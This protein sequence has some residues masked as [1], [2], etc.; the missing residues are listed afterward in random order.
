VKANLLA[1][2]AAVRLH[3]HNCYPQ[4]TWTDRL[5][6]ALGT[7]I[8]PIVIEQDLVWRSGATVVAHEAE[9]AAAAPTLEE[10]FFARVG[11]MLDRALAEG[12]R[13]EWPVAVL[14][15]DFKTNEP[16]H[17]AEVWRLLGK[18]ERW[19]TTAERTAD[20]V[21]VTPLSPGPLLVLTERGTG[22][23]GAFH[24]RIPVGA[25]LRLFGT[26]APLPPPAGREKDPAA[27]VEAAPE[28]LIP[29]GATNYRRWTNHSW[30][31]V[32]A[33]GPQKAGDWTPADRARLERIVTRAHDVGLWV[34]FYTLN[35]H[36]V[37][38]NRGWSAS[39]NFGSLDAARA[40]WRAA[41]DARVDFVA[42][43]QY[44]DFTRELSARGT[45]I[46]YLEAANDA[47]KWIRSTAIKTAA[48]L[49]WP[50]DPND[51]KSAGNTTL[52]SGSPGVVLFL[53]ELHKATGEASY[54]AD[55]RAGADELIAQLSKV[56]GAGLYVGLAGIGFTLAETHLATGDLRY[57]DAFAQVV[58]TVTE[59]ARPAGKG[60]DWGGVTDIIAG[61]AGTGLF[62]LYASDALKDT[63]ATVVAA[64][65]ADRLLELGLPE[66]G[67]LKWP[68]ASGNARLMPNFSHG[69]AG[70]A[71]FL[72]RV[73][74]ATK[75]RKYLD[76]AL[77]GAKYL[78]TAAKTD[79]DT[80]LIPHHEPDG[81][82]LFYLGW[83]HGP[84]GTARLWH[85][86]AQ[87]TGDRQWRTWVD[88]SARTLV[89]SGIPEKRTEGFW[90]NVS[91][92]CGSAG[93]AQ[94]FLDLY[95]VTKDA[96]HLEFAKRMTVDLLA[97]ATRDDKGLRW[98]QA[99]HR[100]QPNLLVA[101]AG[102]MQGAAGIGMWLLRLDGAES[103]R[104]PFVTFP[105]SPW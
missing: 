12:R 1:P 35:G 19:L 98:V 87:V 23:E 99:E 28:A 9:A 29:G 3:A 36:G 105:D 65:A 92:C 77:A 88:R 43:D 53:L 68:M 10:H 16:E 61:S 90:N 41:I 46:A 104:K 33:G 32:E 40:R 2:G 39:Y 25:R 52:Y 96:K 101:Q 70:I 8:R 31:V 42:T 50:A 76:G 97:R 56:Q 66:H 22:Q 60:E 7:G 17:H 57:R 14:H 72:A 63:G 37:D 38:D 45:S 71:Y 58:R 69:T 27:A 91:Q 82:E 51:P 20:P 80:C 6:R 18:Y 15:L 95:G 78:Q 54:L 62:L 44:E 83:C 67:G 79:G 21:R 93:V 55:A 49:T 74:E 30:A 64:K 89:Q 47:A 13:D 100:V 26:V 73:Y 24:D 59:R 5:D 81:L 86:L 94:F 48:G 85:K 103:G 75:D 34:R 11:P 102:Y 4:G 84:A